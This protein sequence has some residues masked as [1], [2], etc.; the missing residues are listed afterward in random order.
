MLKSTYFGSLH[1]SLTS[2][3][4]VETRTKRLQGVKIV[5]K[6][7]PATWAKEWFD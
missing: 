6:R 2:V 1:K 4:E 3:K 7:L 5:F